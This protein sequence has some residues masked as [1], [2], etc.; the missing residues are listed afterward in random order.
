[1]EPSKV[2]GGARAEWTAMAPLTWDRHTPAP[3]RDQLADTLSGTEPTPTFEP[4]EFGEG[5]GERTVITT[6]SPYDLKSKFT[7]RTASIRQIEELTTKAFDQRQLAFC[8]VV[9][10]PGMGKS[11]IVHELVA[12]T[13]SMH[14]NLLVAAGVADENA[15]AYGPVARALTVRFGL[16]PGEDPPE[17][18]DKIQAI[19]SEIVPA[20]RVAEIAHLVAHLLRVPFDDSPVVT[21][22]LESPQRL[23]ARLF[24]ALKRMLTAEA[25][26]R[27]VVLIVEN[28]ELCG[29]DTINF[30]QYL[31]AGMRDQPVAILGTATA[32]LYDK[33]PAFG[34]GEDRAGPADARRERAA[35]QGAVQAA[36]ERAAAA[37]RAC[38]YARR[39]A[40]RDSRARAPAPR[41]RRDRSRGRD[42]ARR[43][44]EDRVVRAAEDV[45]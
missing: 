16:Q 1:M 39:L 26:K 5:E 22:L 12:R 11:R 31:A 32:A 42:V 35:P 17:S 15:H 3:N 27:P 23:E 2:R 8:V 41:E 37:R 6:A 10:E 7:G 13:K 19:V 29:S 14:P 24:M 34:A 33:H 38:A 25:E 4:S 43:R 18:R 36:T 28:L 9:G 20:Q 44:G 45:R 40:A 21:P 30:L